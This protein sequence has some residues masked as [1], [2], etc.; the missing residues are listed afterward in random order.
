MYSSEQLNLKKKI[1]TS[2]FLYNELIISFI[3]RFT[4]AWKVNVS[5]CSLSSF[6]CAAFNPSNLI[7]SSATIAGLL[8]EIIFNFN[9]LN[10]LVG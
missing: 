9:I 10:T 2:L 5:A 3:I 1:L 7:R 8:S 6:N 4:S